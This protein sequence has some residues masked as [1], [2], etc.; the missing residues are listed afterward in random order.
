MFFLVWNLPLTLFL[1]IFSSI[2]YLLSLFFWGVG[3]HHSVR[4]HF[5]CPFFL[6]ILSP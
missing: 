5:F 4:C 2:F 1:F 3:G 6:F